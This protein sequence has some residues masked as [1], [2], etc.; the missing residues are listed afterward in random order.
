[1][2]ILGAGGHGKVVADA[3]MASREWQEV[4]F[5]D[6]RTTSLGAVLGLQVLGNIAALARF[7]ER[8]SHAVVAVGNSRLRLELIGEA[9]RAGYSVA[10]VV[11]PRATVSPSAV[12]G[13]GTVVMAGAVVNPDVIAGSGVI[14]NTG[15][16]VDHDCRLGDGVHVCPGVC[17]AGDVIVGDRSWIGIGAC[18]R[19][20]VTIGRDVVVG[21]GATVTSNV[22]DGLT[23]VGTP[24]RPIVRSVPAD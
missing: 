12:L 7:T 22:I 21:A 13:V 15:A 20:G 17:L 23:V 14:I 24:A 16:C 19:Q 18:S 2:L 1:L 10:V 8:F 4:A 6:D 9:G 5:L 11:H 3:A